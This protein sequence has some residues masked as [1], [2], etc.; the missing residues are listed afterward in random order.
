MGLISCGEMPLAKSLGIE[1]K[2]GA[3][4]SLS[5]KTRQMGGMWGETARPSCVAHIYVGPRTLSEQEQDPDEGV[6][7]RALQLNTLL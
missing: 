1:R 3:W 2:L 6:H 5:W 7:T 4:M